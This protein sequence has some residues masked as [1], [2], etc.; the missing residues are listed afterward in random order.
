MLLAIAERHGASVAQVV[1]RW[2][3]DQG[4]GLVPKSVTPSR[5]RTNIDI[6]EVR[7]TRSDRAAINRLD[8]GERRRPAPE[9]VT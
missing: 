8:R 3:V 6:D 5:S 1:L 9:T 2:H 4:R 7:L